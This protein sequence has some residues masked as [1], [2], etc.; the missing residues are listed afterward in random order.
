VER[1]PPHFRRVVLQRR[2]AGD[3]DPAAVFGLPDTYRRLRAEL[4]ELRRHRELPTRVP[5]PPLDINA[6][7]AFV[8]IDQ[9]AGGSVPDATG[10]PV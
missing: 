8:F 4:D 9:C 7:R 3:V 5:R 6:G 2:R 10:T 1:L